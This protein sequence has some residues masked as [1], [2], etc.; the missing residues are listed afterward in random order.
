M[1]WR[2]DCNSVHSPGFPAAAAV[3][4]STYHN[5]PFRIYYLTTSTRYTTSVIYSLPP[6]T[7]SPAAN[8]HSQ[9]LTGM[10]VHHLCHRHRSSA[11]TPSS[12]TSLASGSSHKLSLPP[13]LRVSAH[14]F[15]RHSGTQRTKPPSCR[16]TQLTIHNSQAS[17]SSSFASKVQLRDQRASPVHPCAIPTLPEHFQA[18][19][20]PRRIFFPNS[21]EHSGLSLPT[22][23]MPQ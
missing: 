23:A 13:P 7:S 16:Q 1:L 19:S 14:S 2:L 3:D 22:P 9:P 18:F 21:G 10:A 17:L 4:H 8:P 20:A 6:V 5:R 12:L 11:P 15:L